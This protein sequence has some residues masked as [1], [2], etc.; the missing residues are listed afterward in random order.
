MC[1]S[2]WRD[3]LKKHFDFF[4][5][6]TMQQRQQQ[7]GALRTGAVHLS[8]ENLPNVNMPTRT[9]C[10]LLSPARRALKRPPNRRQIATNSNSSAELLYYYIFFLFLFKK[11]NNKYYHC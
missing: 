5:V 11:I 10:L 2:S 7:T 4:A 3:K 1:P 6:T 8:C 9:L